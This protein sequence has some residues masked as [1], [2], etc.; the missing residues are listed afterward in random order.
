MRIPN[1]VLPNFRRIRLRR[2]R[3][4]DRTLSPLPPSSLIKRRAMEGG[5]ASGQGQA[6]AI[7]AI[8]LDREAIA[9]DR[10]LDRQRIQEV[11]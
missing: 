9:L 5:G 1:V 4:S 3:G 8:E 6:E 10:E 2:G 11:C 7:A